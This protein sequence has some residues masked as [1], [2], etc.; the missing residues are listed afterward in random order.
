MTSENVEMMLKNSE[1]EI[2]Q[3]SKQQIVATKPFNY[4]R[5]HIRLKR[6]SPPYLLKERYYW[7]ADIHFEKGL[8]PQKIFDSNEIRQFVD[9]HIR[10]Y[11]ESVSK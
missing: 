3:E 7:L 1:Y 9:K 10:P 5:I 6:K 11:A 4:G 8:R 2:F